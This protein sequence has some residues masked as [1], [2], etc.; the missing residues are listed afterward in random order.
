LYNI[1]WHEGKYLISILVLNANC[2]GL[3]FQLNI[4]KGEDI[5]SLPVGTLRS[6]LKKYSWVERRR[7]SDM[8]KKISNAFAGQSTVDVNCIFVSV[9]FPKDNSFV[10]SENPGKF[11]I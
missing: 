1:V 7:A 5:R 3:F 11:D 9:A 10:A 6:M 4:S 8:Q 2:F